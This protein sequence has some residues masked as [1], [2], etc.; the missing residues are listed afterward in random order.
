MFTFIFVEIVALSR[1]KIVNDRPQVVVLQLV[2]LMLIYWI[3][4]YSV[5]SAF[6]QPGQVY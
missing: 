3:V 2:L 1:F 6:E 5:D 4:I